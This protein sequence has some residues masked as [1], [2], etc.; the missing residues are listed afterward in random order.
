M[1]SKLKVMELCCSPNKGG[2]ELYYAD[3]CNTLHD[4]CDVLQVVGQGSQIAPLLK[5]KPVISI[6]KTAR[7]LPLFAALKLANV[8][9]KHG[10]EIIHLHWNHDLTL[11]VLAKIFSKNKPKI[12]LTRHMQFPSR[13]DSVFHRFLYKNIDHIMAITQTMAKDLKRFIPED[14]QPTISVNYLGV[15]PAKQADKQVIQQR[16]TQYDADGSHFLIAL[17]GRIDYD[18]GHE[19]LLAALK[20]AKDKGL[21]FKALIVGHPM[22]ESYL[23]RLKQKVVDA[24]LEQQMVFTGFVDNPKE[25]MQACDVLIL[26]TI[27]ETFGLVLIEAM[28]VGIPVIG[29]NRGGVP[30]IISHQKTG[31]LFESTDAQSLFDA[32]N[33]L[34]QS[35]ETAL[36]YADKGLDVV[37]DK[38]DKQEH[39]NRLLQT[40]REVV[41]A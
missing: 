31:L 39:L 27:E 38:F 4:E 21:P 18:K 6:K 28:S 26:P 1:M 3:I 35:P 41:D 9:D 14:V 5:Q 37:Q 24:G 7:Y 8:I 34:Y 25:L 30:E 32:L 16:R 12:M 20:I 19:F 13:K 22:Q 33:V 17:V 10:I 36:R 11:V 29:S 40:L 23:E 15:S 2:L